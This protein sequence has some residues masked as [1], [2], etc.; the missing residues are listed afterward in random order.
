MTIEN[1][2]IVGLN[3]IQSIRIMS[4]Y[5]TFRFGDLRSNISFLINSPEDPQ[6][7]SQ[8]ALSADSGLTYLPVERSGCVLQEGLN[9]PHILLPH[10][11][12]LVHLQKTGSLNEGFIV[13]GHN[14]NNSPIREVSLSRRI[15]QLKKY[16]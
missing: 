8:I 12:F 11:D 14:L 6:I 16:R 1:L 3:V 9:F 13:R 7:P 2:D 15:G 4:R 10:G 5:A